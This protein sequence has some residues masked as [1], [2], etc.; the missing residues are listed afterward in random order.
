MAKSN[1]RLQDV[2]EKAKK[3]QK[4]TGEVVLLKRPVK[5]LVHPEAELVEEKEARIY[6][7][8]FKFN[9]DDEI[10]LVEKTYVIEFITESPE[11]MML[12]RNLAN[13]RLKDDYKRLKE[14]GIEI[15]EKYFE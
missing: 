4:A 5:F 14:A 12:N 8:L 3:A 11:E 1:L 6:A 15:E 13:A 10:M 2:I 7:A 9:I